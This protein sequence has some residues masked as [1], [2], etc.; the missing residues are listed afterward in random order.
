MN[1]CNEVSHLLTQTAQKLK[2]QVLLSASDLP[3]ATNYWQKPS[4]S[5]SPAL[6]RSLATPLP[7][8]E[9][10]E[11][12]LQ[13][14]VQPVQPQKPFFGLQKCIFPFKIAI[15][16]APSHPSFITANLVA[17]ARLRPSKSWTLISLD[18]KTLE[19]QAVAEVRGPICQN[20]K[21]KVAKNQG[22]L[23]I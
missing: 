3:E 15:A 17:P 20:C 10:P 1:T 4:S 22:T 18:A 16:V 23:H 7:T 13:L 5:R 14:E 2:Y 9:R 12:T 6:P 19:N 8:L 11:P 21:G